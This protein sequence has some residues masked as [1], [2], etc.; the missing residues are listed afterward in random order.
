[1]ILSQKKTAG[2][3]ETNW[4]KDK[5]RAGEHM[6]IIS[7]SQ[8]WSREPEPKQ[9]QN[10]PKDIVTTKK[11]V[12]PCSWPRGEIMTNLNIYTE[13]KVTPLL[14]SSFYLMA[15]PAQERL[16]STAAVKALCCFQKSSHTAPELC[17]WT[18]N[19]QALCQA[20]FYATLPAN[21]PA[22]QNVPLNRQEDLGTLCK[23][24][25]VSAL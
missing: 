15:R 3:K 14:P 2:W 22:F 4:L 18:L 12:G 5:H 9:E 8:D 13:K 10:K 17:S 11:Q 19:R 23:T 1:M 7:Q 20:R 16:L 6:R 24:T 21:T 25:A